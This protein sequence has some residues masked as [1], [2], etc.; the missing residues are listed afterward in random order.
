MR[1]TVLPPRERAPH[2]NPQ[3]RSMPDS[4]ARFAGCGPWPGPPRRSARYAVAPAVSWPGPAPDRSWPCAW[5]R[6]RRPF[7]LRRRWQQLIVEPIRP[8]RIARLEPVVP[9]QPVLE[10]GRI[11]GI[12]FWFWIRVCC[13][14]MKWHLGH[15]KWRRIPPIHIFYEAVGVE[16]VIAL[17]MCGQRGQL[18]RI[19][20]RR[21]LLATAEHD[22][23]VVDVVE[24][25]GHVAKMRVVAT[26]ALKRSAQAHKI[27]VVVEVPRA[28]ALKL[29]RIAAEVQ[30]CAGQ[31]DLGCACL[32]VCA[33]VNQHLIPVKLQI[34]HQA[35]ALRSRRQLSR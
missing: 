27:V 4:A 29:L 32:S 12:F 14:S 33:L 35:N 23:S 15:C 6:L 2:R 7:F 8:H 13:H 24:Q 31:G 18:F 34:S 11:V 10:R 21:D 17:P 19:E 5:L 22:K 3:M 25:W 9:I 16:K 30:H 20:F 1:P 28:R 26:L